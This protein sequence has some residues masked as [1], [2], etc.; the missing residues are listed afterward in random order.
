MEDHIADE[1]ERHVHQQLIHRA[2][3]LIRAEFTTRTWQAFWRIVVDGQ[4]TIDVAQEL[5][6]QPGAVRVAKSRVL[7]R[8]RQE[9][10]ELLE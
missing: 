1:G 8:L 5:S 3:E 7:R 2:L 4:Q 10:G 9:L 6:M